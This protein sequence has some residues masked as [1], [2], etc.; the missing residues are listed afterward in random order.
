MTLQICY[1]FVNKLTRESTIVHKR[2]LITAP[3]AIST[4]S[5]GIEG[6]GRLLPFKYV[7]VIVLNSIYECYDSFVVH[8][9]EHQEITTLF[10]LM[11]Y[12][13]WKG[14]ARISIS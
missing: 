4:C 14:L 7:S 2:S 5:N 6:L 12:Y 9:I 13:I 10:Y 3:F 11:S 1:L 8:I